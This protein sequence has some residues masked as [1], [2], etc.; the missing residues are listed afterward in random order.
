[1]GKFALYD[2]AIET[3]LLFERSEDLLRW[4]DRWMDMFKSGTGWSWS[5]MYKPSTELPSE[6]TLLGNVGEVDP[7]TID[8][9]A[10]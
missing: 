9:V 4:H 3:Y 2:K 7:R 5:A 8:M 6:Y 1:M 10:L